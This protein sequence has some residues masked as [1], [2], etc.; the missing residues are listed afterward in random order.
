MRNRIRL[1]AV[2]S[3]ITIPLLAAKPQF[4]SFVTQEDFERGKA[5]G[6]AIDALGQLELA[7]AV[8]EM[9]RAT[10]P[11]LWCSALDEQGAIWVGG[12]NP[13][14][15]VRIRA[16]QKSDTLFSSEEVAVFSLAAANNSVYFA[17][18]PDGQVYRH[19]R[20]GRIKPIFKP[21][22]KYIWA[23]EPGDGGSL[24]VATGEPARIYLVRPSGEAELFFESEETHIRSLFWDRH[25]KR[26][27]AG[28]SS[29]GYLYR[30]EANGKAVVLYDAPLDE[31]NRIVVQADGTIYLAAAG[32]G[33][34]R[35]GLPIS[36]QPE[37]TA[38]EKDEDEGEVIHIVAGGDAVR[39]ASAESPSRVSAA[40]A[41]GAIYSIDESGFARTVWSSRTD[42][43]HSLSLAA[44][45]ASKSDAPS[46]LVGTGDKGK[47]Y[48]LDAEGNRTLLFEF[49]PSQITSFARAADGQ[50]VITTA[51]PATVQILSQSG[52]KSGE[53]L[54][55]VIDASVPTQWGA[56]SWQA[57][58]HGVVKMFTRS[59]NTGKPDK[60]WSEWRPVRGSSSEGAIASPPARFLQ[61]KV[62]L[63]GSGRQTPVVKRVRVSYLQKNV[64]PEITK[65]TVYPPGDAFPDAKT[66][67]DHHTATL[68]D[69]NSG[70]GNSQAPTPGRKTHK[71]GAQSVGWK[72]HDENGDQLQFKLEIRAAG[73][74]VWHQLIADYSGRAFTF[75]SRALPDGEY[76]ARVT[77]T[78]RP[79]NPSE[80]ARESVKTSEL[81]V[82]DNTPPQVNNLKVQSGGSSVV[83]TF[84]AR[85]QYSRIQEASYALNAGEWQLVYPV[86]QVAD[87]RTEA[88]RLSLPE[89][90]RGKVLAVKVTDQ[91]GN[92][93][94]AKVNIE[95]K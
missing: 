65:I 66:N 77:A 23:V 44:G 2:L 24:Y 91:N 20:D 61:W 36:P 49:E 55:E 27:Y 15:V 80:L 78:D 52:R 43:V 72:A 33:P 60:T 90:C 21:E 9:Y 79:G 70:S 5:R 32:G 86:D 13:A 46:L 41:V 84:Q 6:V 37:P 31:I 18:S 95:G 81:F 30:L 75:D 29:N 10:V 25:T 58:N 42:R 93:G 48:R 26:L 53:Y 82:I 67:A 45:P 88:H 68:K 38:G 56:V 16:N 50:T 89:D 64:A 54:S 14:L 85:D 76:Q 57:N 1:L 83:V 94:F 92:I 71:Q 40:G 28:S 73:E 87:Q 39:P 3:I 19:T 7:P 59:G 8:K 34:I 35:P 47:I 12:G 4:K 17:T 74:K 63:E 51:N 69:G 62:R 22:A 11:H